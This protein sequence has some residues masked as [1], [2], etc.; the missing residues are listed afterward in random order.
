MS[1]RVTLSASRIKTAQSC[2]WL[3]WAKYKLK[4]PDKGNE[5]A[6]RGTV[7]H[8]VFELLGDKK[9]KKDF[10]KIIEK[11]DIFASKKIK[12]LAKDDEDF[13]DEDDDDDDFEN[14]TENDVI[15]VDVD[16]ITAK[17]K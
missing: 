8:E 17:N 1:E 16:D 9:H 2:S 15:M 14:L 11:Q 12:D 7:C 4:L 6:S 13:Y 5:G 10:D 3:Y